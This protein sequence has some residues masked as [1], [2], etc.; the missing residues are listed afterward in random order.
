[1]LKIFSNV[2]KRAMSK[3]YVDMSYIIGKREE[4]ESDRLVRV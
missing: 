1:M 2:L 4:D 3:W